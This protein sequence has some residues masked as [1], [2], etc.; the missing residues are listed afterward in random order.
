MPIQLPPLAV[1]GDVERRISTVGVTVL[2]AAYTDLVETQAEQLAAGS[3]TS[4]IPL[5]W[6]ALAET[7]GLTVDNAGRIVDGPHAHVPGLGSVVTYPCGES[8]WTPQ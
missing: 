2:A 1:L 8:A 7:A 4:E 6:R 3:P 5:L